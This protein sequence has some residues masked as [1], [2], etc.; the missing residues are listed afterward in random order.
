MSWSHGLRKSN[1]D[2]F[3]FFLRIGSLA[4]LVSVTAVRTISFSI[5][6]KAKYK[7]SAAIGKATG[8]EEPLVIVNTPGSTPTLGTVTCFAAAGGLTG[9]LITV[10]ACEGWCFLY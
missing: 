3:H 2:W 7:F 1:A 10:I 9:G 6:Q 5:Y 4:P 8:G